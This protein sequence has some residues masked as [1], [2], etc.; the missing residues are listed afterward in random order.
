[1]L[2]ALLHIAGTLVTLFVLMVVSG[3]VSE[4]RSQQRSR[5]VMVKA[6]IHLDVPLQELETGKH[7]K[8]LARFLAERF[9]TDRISNRLSDLFRPLVIVVEGISYVS[10]LGVVG[11]AAWR[12]FTVDPAYGVHA[13]FA[14]GIALFFLIVVA[15][16]VAVCKL[17]T[18][19]AP[20]EA[21]HGRAIAV[22]LTR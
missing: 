3:A 9:D 15:I 8:D 7:D 12:V 18:G 1:M 19:R 13:W 2:W 17:V 4:W 22:S 21:K 16:V 20:G 10:Q 6:A 11:V 5:D 14:V